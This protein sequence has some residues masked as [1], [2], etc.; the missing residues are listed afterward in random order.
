MLKFLWNDFF[1]SSRLLVLIGYLYKSL[2]LLVEMKFFW[3]HMKIEAI[4]I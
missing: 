1:L 4:I 2:S 3:V